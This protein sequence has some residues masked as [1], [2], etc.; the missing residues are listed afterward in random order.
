M[1]T[2]NEYTSLYLVRWQK[3]FTQSKV[4]E[5]NMS[6]GIQQYVLKLNVTIYNAQLKYTKFTI[7][8][9]KISTLNLELRYKVQNSTKNLVELY[10]ETFLHENFENRLMNIHRNSSACI[11]NAITKSSPNYITP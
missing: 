5:Y 11:L 8:I 4:G 6:V 10:Y 2:C 3:F 1:V 7:C 9:V